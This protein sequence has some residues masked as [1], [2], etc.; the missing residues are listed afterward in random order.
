[1]YGR[2]WFDSNRK[3]KKA[4]YEGAGTVWV[5]DKEIGACVSLLSNKLLDLTQYKI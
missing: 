3:I 2:R 4:S 1:M 5:D